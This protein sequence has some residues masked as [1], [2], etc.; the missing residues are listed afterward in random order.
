MLLG[1]GLGAIN[2]L[3]IVLTRIPDIV[4]TLSFFFI[5][6]GVALLILSSP[7]GDVRPFGVDVVGVSMLSAA[8]FSLEYQSE[9]PA[10]VS[11]P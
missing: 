11:M 6:E 1:A 5:W 8:A 7:G 2:G 10:K 4:V 3:T 9:S